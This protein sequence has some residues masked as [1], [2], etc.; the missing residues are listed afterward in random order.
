MPTIF[1]N[2]FWISSS[3]GLGLPSGTRIALV[4]LRAIRNRH[5][6]ALYQHLSR[7][8]LLAP[9]AHHSVPEGFAVSR[10]GLQSW[11][12]DELALH[13]T[14]TQSALDATPEGVGA[15]RLGDKFNG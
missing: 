4:L 12:D 15:C 2:S 3:D 8:G 6:L 1:S 7:H 14:V 13:S 10:S 5:D 9:I 11:I